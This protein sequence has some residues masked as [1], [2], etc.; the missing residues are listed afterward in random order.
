MEHHQDHHIAPENSMT[1]E[2]Q[3]LVE[4]YEHAHLVKKHRGFGTKAIH[5]GQEPDPISGG[6]TTAINLST[7]YAQKFPGEPFGHFDY[8]VAV[9]PPEKLLRR[10]W[11]LLSTES[12]E[13]PSPVAVLLPQQLFRPS[14]AEET[15]LSL[16][17]MCTEALKD[18]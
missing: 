8:A 6:V 18:T 15:T 16:A 3:K 10:Q 7:T 17:M 2:V 11:Q 14:A 5:S 13:W 9:I 1:P 4:K 12:T